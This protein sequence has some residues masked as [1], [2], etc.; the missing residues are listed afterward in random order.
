MGSTCP[1]ASPEGVALNVIGGE[2]GGRKL[3]SP[4]RTVRPTAAI[5]RRSLFDILGPGIAGKTVLDLYAGSGSLGLEAL[6][7]GARRCDFVE[8]DRRVANV[9]KDNLSALVGA[10]ESE[11]GRVHSGAVERWLERSGRALR[12]YD[13]VLIDPPYGDP[14]LTGVLASIGRPGALKE[15]AMVVVE[16]RS[17]ERPDP[18]E[19]LV[20]VRRV[21]HGD[22]MLV[23]M[24]SEV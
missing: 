14:G 3:K 17:D 7:R 1:E 16:R 9:V 19:G 4:P 8:R 23:M 20:E 5:L 12:E 21:S 10:A 22:S 11:R 2:W 6:S 18:V 15:T 13:L 24:R